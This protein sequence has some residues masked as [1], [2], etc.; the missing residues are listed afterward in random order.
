VLGWLE[1]AYLQ[2]WGIRVR[3]KLDTGARTSSL[4][5]DR[6]TTFEQDGETWVRFHLPY[7]R[8]EGFDQGVVIER[9]LLREAL[10]KERMSESRSRYVVELDVCVS[11]KTYT[12]PVSLFDRSNFNYPMIL[13]RLMLEGNIIVDSS[14]TFLGT[15]D[16]HR[17]RR[18]PAAASGPVDK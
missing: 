10:V 2:P 8:R 17:A 9:P 15:R 7:G 12:T 1:G 14:R 3:A 16:C 11:G 5:A 4:H 13:G 6:I 18:K